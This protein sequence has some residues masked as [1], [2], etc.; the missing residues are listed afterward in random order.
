MQSSVVAQ[1]GVSPQSEGFRELVDRE[2]YRVVGALSELVHGFDFARLLSLYYK[3]YLD[4][5]DQLKANVIKWFR[6][7]Y[8]S[9]SEARAELGVN[10]IITDDDWYDYIKLFSLFLHEAGYSGLLVLIDELVNIYKVPNAITRQYN[11]EKLLTMYNDA[12]QG[13]AS[14]MGI[15]MCGTPQCIE[16]QRRGLYSYEALRSRLADGRFASDK[17]DMMAPV[18]KLSPLTAEEMLVLAEKLEEIHCGLY[19]HAALLNDKQREDFIK[20]EYGRVGA[21]QNITPREIIRDFIQLLNVLCQHPGTSPSELIGSG[22]F[23]FSPSSAVSDDASA[24]DEYSE[25]EI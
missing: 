16:D 9:K 21:D 5:D 22:E 8:S 2:I 13:R 11:Y 14:Y 1:N 4:G 3:A 15:I 19:D 17:R 7:E 18:I 20:L 23:T 24:K 12:L 6:G 25:F 10:I